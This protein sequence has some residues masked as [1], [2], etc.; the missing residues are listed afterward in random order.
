MQA[1]PFPDAAHVSVVHALRSSQVLQKLP[2]VPQ[3]VAF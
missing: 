2:A 3:L 1:P